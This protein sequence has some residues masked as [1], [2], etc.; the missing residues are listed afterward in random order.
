MKNALF[1]KL[2]ASRIQSPTVTGKEKWLGYL[3]GPAG[4]LLLNAVLATYLN[5]YY[6]DV[7]NLTPLWNGL[8]LTVFPIVSKVIDAITNVI[9]GQLID[10]T[11]SKEGKARPWL[12]LSA[13]LVPLTGILLFTVPN[14]SNTVKAIWVMISYNLFYSFAYTIFN[15]SHNLM[16]PLSTRDTTQRGGLSVFNQIT[17][18]MMSGILVALVFPMVIMPMVGVR[19]ESWIALMSVLSILALPLTLLEYFFTKERVTEEQNAA[20]QAVEIPFRTQ[21]KTIFTDKY[22]M[23]MYLYFFIYTIGMTLKNMGLVYYC[24]Y[25]LGTYNDG[26]TQMLVSVIGGIPMG[27]G[28]FAVWPLAKRFGKRNVTMVGFILYAIGGLICWLFPANLVIVLAGQFIKNIGGLP[29]SYVFMA[30]FADCLDHMEWKKHLRAD[31]TAMSIYN[32]IAVAMVGI[33]TGVFNWLLAKAGYLAPFAAKSAQEAAQTL[34]QN[35]WLSQ[36][37]LE[38][39][40]PAADGTLTVALQQSAGVNWVITFAF[41]GVEVFTGLALVAILFFLRVEKD[42][43]KMQAESTEQ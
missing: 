17:T 43:S 15:M 35:G 20:S 29:C 25:V 36:L 23:L 24:N 3:L 7:L 9:M 5:V 38:A 39:I 37:P 8:F 21:M 10:H 18:I 28:I 30:L 42:L 4:A 34:S 6:T 33:M 41:V 2:P 1:S 14:G 16:V 31:G 27:I 32:I 11:R 22:M 26:R 19:R 13:F 40:K 12:L